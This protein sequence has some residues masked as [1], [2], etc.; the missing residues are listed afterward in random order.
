VVRG[1]ERI[2]L[3]LAARFGADALNECYFGWD[4]ALAPAR[5]E[6]NLMRAENQLT[7]ARCIGKLR[8]ELNLI[9]HGGAL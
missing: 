5:G 2:T 4:P 9:V 8:S 7:L 6:H 3:E 1:L